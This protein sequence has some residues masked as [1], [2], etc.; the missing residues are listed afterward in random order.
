[1][2]ISS[3]VGKLRHVPSPA[4]RNSRRKRAEARPS[5]RL[6]VRPLEA[7]TVPTVIFTPAFG[8][9][10]LLNTPNGDHNYT[11]MSNASVNL[12][13]WG[14]F[15]KDSNGN[16]PQA[17]ALKNDVVSILNSAYLSKLQQYGGSDGS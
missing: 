15:W 10:Q 1:M 8:S 6:V 17:D 11:T 13:F 5:T 9:E 7:R 14:T 4:R 12:I 16:T 3:L 2:S